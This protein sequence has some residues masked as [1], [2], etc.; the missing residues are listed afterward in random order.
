MALRDEPEVATTTIRSNGVPR[1]SRG[2]YR[3]QRHQSPF[4]IP[5]KA[6]GAFEHLFVGVAKRHIPLVLSYSPY[7]ASTRNRPRLLTIDQL[8]GIAEQH[9]NKVELLPVDGVSH[10]KLN[11]TERNVNVECH[12]EVLISCTP[13]PLHSRAQSTIARLDLEEPAIRPS[14]M[15]HLRGYD[16]TWKFIAR[17]IEPVTVR[18]KA[19]RHMWVGF[20]IG[21]QDRIAAGLMSDAM[22]D[23]DGLW[24]LLRVCA[25]CRRQPE[26]VIPILTAFLVSAHH[27]FRRAYAVGLSDGQKMQNI[28]G[29]WSDVEEVIDEPFWE[30]SLAPP[31]WSCQLGN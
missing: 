23:T 26:F 28:A 31:S 7:Q 17:A 4:C 5:S 10:N 30:C 18:L 24:G 14:I 3:L 29:A 20:I 2:V 9:F 6:A 16:G 11:V 15:Q 12:A 8:L 13:K 21:H 19:A 1:L 25:D 22:K 27:P